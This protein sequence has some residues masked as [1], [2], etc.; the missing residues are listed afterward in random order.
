MEFDRVEELLISFSCTADQES[1][2]QRRARRRIANL[3][4]L[5]RSNPFSSFSS[6]DMVILGLVGGGFGIKGRM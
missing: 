6:S 2:Y 5:A 3:G 4:I 1:S